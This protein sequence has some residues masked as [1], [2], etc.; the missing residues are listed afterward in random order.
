MMGHKERYVCRVGGE[1][2]LSR[3]NSPSK[4]SWR[5]QKA[6]KYNIDGKSHVITDISICNLVKDKEKSEAAD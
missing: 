4:N 5:S 2:S 3:C 6:R 1:A